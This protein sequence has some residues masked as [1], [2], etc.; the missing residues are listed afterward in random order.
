MFCCFENGVGESDSCV[1]TWKHLIFKQIKIVFKVKV[2]NVKILSM[3]IYEL[4]PYLFT[5]LCIY[6][7]SQHVLSS[8]LM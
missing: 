2:K 1:F 6:H 4:N 5:S 3:F 8:H 7:S